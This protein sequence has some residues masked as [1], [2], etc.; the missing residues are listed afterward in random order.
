MPIPPTREIRIDFG[1][2]VRM[3]DGTFVPYFYEGEDGYDTIEWC[4]SQPWSDGN[5]GTIGSSYQGCIQ[6][7]AALQK[8]PHLKAMV[9]R[10]TPCDPFVETPTGLPSPMTLCW[11]HYVSGHMNQL[12]EAVD[13]ERIYQHLPLI[14]MDEHAGHINPN[15]RANIEHPQ[16]DE[17]WASLSYQNKFNQLDVPVLHNSGWYDDEQI[18]TPLDYIGMTTYAAT[19]AARVSQRLLM[20]PWGHV[21]NTTPKL[22]EVDFGPQ[23]LID[24]R[25][26]ELRWFNRW[27][28]GYTNVS[29]SPEEFPVRI[30]IMGINEWRDEDEWP[31][32]RAQWTS[33]YLHSGGYANSRFGDGA[34]SARNPQAEP[35]DSYHYDPAHPVP[36]ITDPTSSQ[37]GGPDDY[38]AI[39]RRDDVL[40]YVTEPFKEEV[41][42]TGPIRVDLYAS[43]SAPD[44]D[45][46]VKL[47]DV[48]PSGFVQR[49]CDGMVRARF[50][51]GMDRPSLIEPGKIYHF[52]IDCWMWLQL[53][54]FFM[55]SGGL[56]SIRERNG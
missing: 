56:D 28:K 2:R 55:I 15:W 9:V 31:L 27:L 26:E 40:V 48:W 45:F 49:L 22:G 47:V 37:I 23:A 32:S 4:A 25:A 44:T 24:L 20:G 17:Y 54:S 13:W 8:P 6:W 12:M 14:T 21:V 35:H 46:M 7:L 36:F 39:E 29:A 33:F 52:L 43:S 30:F 50:R 18:G 3:R 42:V 5:V 1:Q 38:S 16:L 53:A 41:E 34:L 10:V 19:P 51:D 11:L